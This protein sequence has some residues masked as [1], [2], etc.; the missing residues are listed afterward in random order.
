MS[1][2]SSEEAKGAPAAASR[3]ELTPEQIQEQVSLL[4][5]L[6]REGAE[7]KDLDERFSRNVR[8]AQWHM[9]RSMALVQAGVPRTPEKT[10]E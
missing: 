7:M 3:P 9:I 1:E 10:A 4:A 8:P 5:G 2:A 6:I